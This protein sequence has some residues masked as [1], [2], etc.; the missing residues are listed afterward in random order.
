L[1]LA[2]LDLYGKIICI[3]FIEGER[4]HNLHFS[5]IKGGDYCD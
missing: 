5:R 1:R 3:L 4:W 2:S